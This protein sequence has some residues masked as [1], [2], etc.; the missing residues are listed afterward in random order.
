MKGVKFIDSLKF[1]PLWSHETNT[2]LTDIL[3]D[4]LLTKQSK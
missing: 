3:Q 4:K 2:V 1:R